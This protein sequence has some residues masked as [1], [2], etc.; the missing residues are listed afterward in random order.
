MTKRRKF[1]RD[2]EQIK[3]YRVSIRTIMRKSDFRLG[4]EHVRA[5][6]APDYDRYVGPPDCNYHKIINGAWDY[7]RGRLFACIAPVDLDPNSDT[8]ERLYSLALQRGLL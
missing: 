5:G 6:I 8:A 2:V 4:I 1:S 3:T 7:E